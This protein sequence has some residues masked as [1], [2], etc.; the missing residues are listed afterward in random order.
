MNK[1]GLEFNIAVMGEIMMTRPISVFKEP[2][3]LS[4]IELFRNADVA[5]TNIEGLFGGYSGHS[6]STGTPM[7][8]EAWIAEEYKWAGFNL[9]SIAN[10]WITG[11]KAYW[12]L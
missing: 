2:D 4:V 5:L 8:G 9:V 7:S 3:F 6:V 12:P 1:L 10:T 11:L